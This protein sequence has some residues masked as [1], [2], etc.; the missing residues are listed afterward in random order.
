[1]FSAPLRLSRQKDCY[2]RITEILSIVQGATEIVRNRSRR[3]PTLVGKGVEKKINSLK[4]K[5]I[6]QIKERFQ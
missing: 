6:V 1:M 5:K 4:E 2:S 3:S